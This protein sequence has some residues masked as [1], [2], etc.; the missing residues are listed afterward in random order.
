[1][2][3]LKPCPFCGG[4][5]HMETGYSYFRD[6]VIYCDGCDSVFTLDD[7]HSSRDDVKEVWNRRI[8]NDKP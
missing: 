7:C 3:E 6:Y 8:A 2:Y 5:V 4:S 1:M